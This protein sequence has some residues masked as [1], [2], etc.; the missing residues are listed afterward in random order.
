MNINSLNNNKTLLVIIF[1]YF[2]F[3]LFSFLIK[4]SEEITMADTTDFVTIENWRD[5]TSKVI[6]Y[7]ERGWIDISH[8]LNLIETDNDNPEDY[9]WYAIPKEYLHIIECPKHSAIY[10][11]LGYRGK[12]W[13]ARRII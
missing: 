12:R 5:N 11:F 2:Y 10:L 4:M 6:E 13:A 3:L 1:L 7:V 9:D 8:F